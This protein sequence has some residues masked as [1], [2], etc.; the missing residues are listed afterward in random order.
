MFHGFANKKLFCAPVPEL[1]RQFVQLIHEDTFAPGIFAAV[2]TFL[3][4]RVPPL[5]IPTHV[6][7]FFLCHYALL[8]YAWLH[9]ATSK[10]GV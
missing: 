1:V 9:P 2:L 4:I 7:L 6:S 5:T 8:R 10:C 3:G